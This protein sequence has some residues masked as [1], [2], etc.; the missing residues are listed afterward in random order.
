MTKS[1]QQSRSKRVWLGF[2]YIHYIVG[3]TQTW[4]KGVSGSPTV[5]SGWWSRTDNRVPKECGWVFGDRHDAVGPPIHP[6]HRLE[7]G[8]G[9]VTNSRVPMVEPKT[10]K[11]VVWFK[12]VTCTKTK[13]IPMSKVNIGGSIFSWTKVNVVT[14]IYNKWKMIVVTETFSLEECQ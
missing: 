12:R 1:H 13:P 2:G 6:G 10:T 5:I 14:S 4:K 11:M 8:N 7:K 3:W 9:S